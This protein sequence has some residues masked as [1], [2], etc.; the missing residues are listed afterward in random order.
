MI[1]AP[2]AGGKTE[3]A[4]LPLASR[5]A[6]RADSPGFGLLYISPLKALINDQFRR[7]EPLFEALDQPVHRWHGDVS[8]HLKTKA[9]KNPRGLVLITPESLEALFLRRGR[10]IERLFGNLEAVVVDELHSFIGSE[11]GIQLSSLLARLE[12]STGRRI[13][14]IGLSAT[15]GDLGL[16]AE[17]L[18]LG[19]GSNVVCVEGKGEAALRAQIRGY[20][21][22]TEPASGG[23]PNVYWKRAISD[24]LFETLRLGKNLAFATSRDNVEVITDLL[25]IRTEREGLPEAFYAHHGNLSREHREFVEARLKDESRPATAICTSTLELGIDIGAIDAIAQI[26]PPFTVS[27]LRQRL[28]RSGRREGKSAVLRI[29]VDEP[30]PDARSHLLDGLNLKLVQSVAMMRLLI[31]RW[32]EPPVLDGLHLSTLTHQVVAVITERGGAQP[33]ELYDL[34][35]RQGPFRSVS[36]ALFADLLRALARPEAVLIEQSSDGLLLLGEVGEQLADR[37]DFY[38]VFATPEEFRVVHGQHEIGRLSMEFARSVGDLVLLAGRRWRIQSL[39]EPTKTILVIPSPGAVPPG[40]SGGVG[41]VHDVVAREMRSVLEDE[42]VPPFLDGPAAEMLAAARDAFA[43]LKGDRVQWA[44]DNGE[45]VLF[46]WVGHRK[47][48]TLAAAFNVM[49][50]DAGVAGVAVR[51]GGASL[52]TALQVAYGLAAAPPSATMVAAHIEPKV[53]E[54]YHPFLTD[55]LLLQEVAVAVVD[56]REFAKLAA[57]TAIAI[58]ESEVE[59][60]AMSDSNG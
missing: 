47:L 33:R 4:F 44:I 55:D 27:S 31:A 26:G 58:A 53:T 14:R 57:D 52:K 9:R 49:G 21:R 6:K 50:V 3:A 2:T 34:L 54:K 56:L 40:F 48:L 60:A 46:P 39:D 15:L 16:A 20:W 30:R 8:A 38:A 42:E 43:C 29:Y 36:T 28:G 25:R 45:L 37:Y 18:R 23:T 10:E 24:H 1:S 13:D 22:E 11:R 12:A 35:C 32:C 17:A 59:V 19:E 51:L 41:G 7:L 5:L